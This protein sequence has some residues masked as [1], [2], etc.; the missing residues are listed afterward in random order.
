VLARGPTYP[1]IPHMKGFY[2]KKEHSAAPDEPASLQLDGPVRLVEEGFPGTVAPGPEFQMNHRAAPRL[3]RQANQLHVRLARSPP[4]F[5]F[6]ALRAGADQVRPVRGPALRTG[7]DVVQAQFA[8]GK[9][10]PAILAPILIAREQ[11]AAVELHPLPRQLVV[12]EQPDHA[13][14]PDLERNGPDPVVGLIALRKEFAILRDFAPALEVERLVPVLGDVD[15]LGDFLAQ[16]RER[17]PG[18][19]YVQ[20]HEIAVQHQ[21]AGLKRR[22]IFHGPDPNPDPAAKP[23]DAQYENVYYSRRGSRLQGRSENYRSKGSDQRAGGSYEPSRSLDQESRSMQRERGE[24][25]GGM[26]KSAKT[27]DPLSAGADVFA[28]SDNISYVTFGRSAMQIGAPVL[29]LTPKIARV[30]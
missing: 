15:D 13:R 27:K 18:R 2:L 3:L 10:V 8:A 21:H 28:T 5:A 6:V 26:T 24:L 19:D 22:R 11:V 4:A 25:E 1:K 23:K 12:A 7:N 29:V 16:K 9:P 30:P 20:R 14:H 17:A